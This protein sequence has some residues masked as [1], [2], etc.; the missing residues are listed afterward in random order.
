M[1]T[2]AMGKKMN[3]VDSKHEEV[4]AILLRTIRKVLSDKVIFQ[5]RLGKKIKDL[6]QRN[7]VK[8]TAA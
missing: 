5:Q 1:V 6:S 3:K 4:G 7:R 8:S 2:S